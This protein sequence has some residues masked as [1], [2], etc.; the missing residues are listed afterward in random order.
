MSGQVI[1]P[2][3]SVEPVAGGEGGAFRIAV[4]VTNDGPE[5]IDP[6]VRQ[7]EVF[8][9]GERSF[10]WGMAAMNGAGTNRERLLDAAETVSLERELPAKAIG[11]P[12]EHELFAV[13]DGERSEPVR[14]T[15]PG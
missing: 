10:A 3:L 6:R 4:A 13:I 7:S 1:R 5:P 9:D 8:V 14:V 15:V 12:G 2:V 11:E